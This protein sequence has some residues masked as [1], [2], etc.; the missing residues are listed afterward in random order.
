MCLVRVLS[1]LQQFISFLS[2]H[3]FHPLS[4]LKKSR[5]SLLSSQSPPRHSHPGASF[6]AEPPQSLLS[7]Q[8]PPSHPTPPSYPASPSHTS[9]TQRRRP[10]Q[11]PPADASHPTPSGNPSLQPI[12]KGNPPEGYAS[13]DFLEQILSIPN[14]GGMVGADG[15]NAS[16]TS[17]LSDT[18]S[19]LGSAVVSLHHPSVMF[20]LSLSLDNGRDAMNEHGGY[21]IKPDAA[22]GGWINDRFGRR[23]S[24]FIADVLFFVGAIVMAVAPAPGVIII[25]RIFVGFG[26]GMASMT[27]PLYILE[28]SPHWIRGALVSTNGL[29]ITG[30]QFISYLDNLA[31]THVTGTW[32]WMLGIA[33]I[34]AVVQFVLMLSL[35]ESPRWLFQN[36]KEEEARLILEKIYPAEEVE[37]F[38]YHWVNLSFRITR[39]AISNAPSFHEVANKIFDVLYGR[40]WAGHNIQRFDCFRIK[41]AFAKINRPAPTPVGMIDSL[42]V[43]TQKFGR[44]A[45]N[46]KMTT[47]AR[48]TLELLYIRTVR[49]LKMSEVRTSTP[50]TGIGG[51]LKKSITSGLKT[52]LISVTLF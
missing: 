22:A 30:G 9:N 7:S 28:A 52:T 27:S 20:P 51:L 38:N 12:I 45:E 42:G 33:G 41:E 6:A 13:D 14:Y 36:G 10:P 11:Q 18:I 48:Y 4:Y 46:M 3:H 49:R 21:A 17:S 24:I 8:S 37:A 23:I 26:V 29:L 16:E 50:T 43:L 5:P 47:L 32:R 1:Q 2:P 39:E 25:G 40:I 44:R 19:Q 35:P 34:P 31:F 15:S